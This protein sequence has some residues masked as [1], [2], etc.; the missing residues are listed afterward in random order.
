MNS[1]ETGALAGSQT[2]LDA[3][4]HALQTDHLPSLLP[5]A[6]DNLY[7]W[8]QLLKQAPAGQFD[9]LSHELQ[10]LY[11]ALGHGTPNGL[12]AQQCLQRLAQLTTQAAASASSELQ[13][14]LRQLGQA[15]EQASQQLNGAL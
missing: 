1:P 5:A 15:L 14:K 2:H 9:D 8:M 6:G 3:T 10:Q 12:Q 7:R 11:N 13:D 4:L